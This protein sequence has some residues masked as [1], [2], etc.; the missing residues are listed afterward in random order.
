MNAFAGLPPFP[1]N[2]V[3]GQ[4]YLNWVW[5]GTM[6]ACQPMGPALNL[7]VFVTSGQLYTASSGLTYA[8]VEVL[9][10]GGGGGGALA[11]LTGV[12]A[13][14]VIGGG[15]GGGGGGYSRSI[16]PA[17]MLQGQIP[18]T[19]GAGGT[20]GLGS[21]AGLAN[22][23][24]GGVSSFAGVVAYGGGGGATNNTTIAG[25]A[26]G[27]PGAGAVFGAGQVQMLGGSGTR[28]LT[29][30]WV[31]SGQA[32]TLEVFGGQGGGNMYA[33]LG[34]QVSAVPGTSG[35]Q[36][37]NGLAGVFSQGGGGGVSAVAST[38]GNGGAG[39][40]GVVIVTEYCGLVTQNPEVPCPSPS[41]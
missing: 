2:P 41:T 22:G 9:G 39:G 33:P 27:R 21:G 16:L 37:A 1:V 12:T 24:N 8:I 15:G 23:G 13:S 28:G 32:A 25:Y 7:K 4:R 3:I 40:G 26:Y 17:A 6:W 31:G 35:A 34:P 18:V 14:G 29:G 20:A 38:F 5:T 36:G 11:L 30:Y 19:L 10:A